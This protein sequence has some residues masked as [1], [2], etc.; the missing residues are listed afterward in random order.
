MKNLNFIMFNLT[1]ARPPVGSMVEKEKH[2][3]IFIT[4]KITVI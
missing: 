2:T 1:S 4:F 3:F